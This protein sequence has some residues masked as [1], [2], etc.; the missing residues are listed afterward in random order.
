VTDDFSD[1][2]KVPFDPASMPTSS[3]GITK[4][5]WYRRPW[6]LAALSLFLIVAISV[7][8][9]LPRPI[10]G[11]Q[12]KA[13]QN[14]SVKEMNTDLA[15]CAFAV[16]ESFHIYNLDVTGKLSKSDLAEVPTLLTGDETA[17]S[18][19]S[20]P[21][22]D[23]TN[24]LQVDDTASGKHIDTMLTVLERWMTD[25]ALASI[26]DI[27]YLFNHPGDAKTIHHLGVQEV[28]LAA[29]RTLALDDEAQAE[30]V[31]GQKLYALKIPSLPHLSGT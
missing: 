14:A 5:V 31:L 12:D 9:D 4:A 24:N 15:P 17:C 19:A 27:Q 21:V 22:F 3:L 26:K 10:T 13:S 8:I 20:E 30:Q 23:L 16:K 11:S 18:F 7:V 28:Q 29:E 1:F 25:F 2:E 6:V